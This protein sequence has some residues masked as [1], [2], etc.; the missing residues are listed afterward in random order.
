MPTPAVDQTHLPWRRLRAF[1]DLEIGWQ[2]GGSAQ[3]QNAHR[4]PFPQRQGV[5]HGV[6]VKAP[7]QQHP[8]LGIGEL[9]NQRRRQRPRV[10]ESQRRGQLVFRGLPGRSR[11]SLG[12]VG[13]CR[14]PL[15]VGASAVRVDGDRTRHHRAPGQ[16]RVE[17]LPGQVVAH[18]QPVQPVGG[19]ER[20][21]G[22]EQDDDD[23]HGQR[24]D[25]DR[26]D[27][28]PPPAVPLAFG[29][30]VPLPLSPCPSGGRCPQPAVPATCTLAPAP[31]TVS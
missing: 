14:Q 30:A 13:Q 27:H 6:V 19:L 21:R 20:P 15:A 11:C 16:R 23:Q 18:V 9:G 1:G 29:R 26:R 4:G 17:G 3:A 24:D 5:A 2:R 12:G 10:D 31:A 25:H 22:D 8:R 7:G 28:L